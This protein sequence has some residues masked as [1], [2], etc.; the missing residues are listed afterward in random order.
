MSTSWMLRCRRTCERQRP[1][2]V[3]PC[4]PVPP[5]GV[6]AA[7]SAGLGDSP[8]CRRRGFWC[9]GARAGGP[10]AA[11]ARGAG[12]CAASPSWSRSGAASCG[13]SAPPRSSSPWSRRRTRR[14]WVSPGDERSPPGSPMVAGHVL[15]VPHPCAVS[16]RDVT[17]EMSLPGC[18]SQMSLR[19]CHSRDVTPRCHS[20]DGGEGAEF[21]PRVSRRSLVTHGATQPHAPVPRLQQSHPPRPR[22]APSPPRLAPSPPRLAPSPPSPAVPGS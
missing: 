15:P 20:G 17:P 13:P 7:P 9:R 22:L 6:P 16:R 11:G 21:T 19:G 4:P 5:R 3:A 8:P 18:H 12:G 1:H 10:G 2:G 14:S